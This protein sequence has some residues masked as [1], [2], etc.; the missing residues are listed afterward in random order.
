VGS[1]VDKVALGQV[2]IRVLPILLTISFH[3]GCSHSYITWGMNDRPLGGSSSE[4]QSHPIDINNMNNLLE[5][6]HNTNFNTV[7]T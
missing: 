6:T 2:F 3:R 1:V 7:L 4:T 5:A